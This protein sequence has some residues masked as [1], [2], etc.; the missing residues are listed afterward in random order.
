MWGW[1]VDIVMNSW[2]GVCLLVSIPIILFSL[3]SSNRKR[4]NKDIEK[5]PYDH[6]KNPPP[7]PGGGGF[8]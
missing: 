6:R 4:M 8:L 1:L 3:A 5:D 7:P 2:L